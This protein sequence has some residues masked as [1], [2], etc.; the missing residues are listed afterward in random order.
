MGNDASFISSQSF[1]NIQTLH[2]SC[3]SVKDWDQ[4]IYGMIIVTEGYY[5]SVKFKPGYIFLAA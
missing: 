4:D 2:L 1:T 5:S 3:K